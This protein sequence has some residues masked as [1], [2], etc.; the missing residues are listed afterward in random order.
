MYNLFTW[1]SGAQS[2]WMLLAGVVLLMFSSVMVTANWAPVRWSGRA[3]LVASLLM[4]GQGAGYAA[5]LLVL[6]ACELLL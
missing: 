3:V 5:A 1:Y 6:R 2:L 4:V